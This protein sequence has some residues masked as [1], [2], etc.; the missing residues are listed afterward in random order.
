[1]FTNDLSRYVTEIVCVL[2]I[3]L[4]EILPW[5]VDSNQCVGW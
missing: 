2:V 5:W 1:M 3:F 4:S